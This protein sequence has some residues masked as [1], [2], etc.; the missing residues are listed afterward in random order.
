MGERNAGSFGIIARKSLFCLFTVTSILFILSWFFVL[1]STGRPHFIDHTLL[2][3]SKLLAAVVDN[4]SIATQ[5]QNDV[6]L[7]IGNRSILVDNEEEEPSS[8][9]DKEQSLAKQGTEC[10]TIDKIV[11][12]VFMYDLPHEFHFGLLDWTPEG[13]SVWPDLRSK[14]PAYPGG[15]NLQHS[16]E[17]WLTLDLLA[18]ELPNAP[19]PRYAV[20]VRNESEADIIFVPF[21]SSL[22]Y[23]RYSKTNPHQKRSNNKMLQ[24]KLV[25]YL[26]AQKEWKRS[27][28]R[29]HLIMAHHPNS[30]LNARM[31]LWPATFILSDFGRYPPNIANVEKDVIAPYK[32]VIRSFVNDT[33]DF[34]S[35][36]TLL[37]FQGAIYRKDVCTLL[38]LYILFYSHFFMFLDIYFC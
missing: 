22:S 17:Y 25:K 26:M 1:R 28:G 20:R 18:S 7:S 33:S 9:Q 3:N 21:F 12:K 10:V 14:V 32:H 19:N 29:D 15:L 5:S 36:P 16:I 23:N 30:M 8:P 2:P 4:G 24:E 13:N 27:G 37:Y 6:E 11:L 31:K 38:L 35:R 34:D